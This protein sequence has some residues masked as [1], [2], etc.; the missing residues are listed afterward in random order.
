[1]PSTRTA[2][3]IGV[4][5]LLSG[6]AQHYTP[7]ISLDESPETIPLRVELRTLKDP[8]EPTHPGQAYGVVAEDV[9]GPE[10]E[11]LPVRLRR[12]SSPTFARILSFNKSIAML[13]I[14][15]PF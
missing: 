8:P 2:Y 3:V 14:Q 1:M 12:P 6:C 4:C 10:R 9:K 15:T 7:K 11:D 5:I 13:K